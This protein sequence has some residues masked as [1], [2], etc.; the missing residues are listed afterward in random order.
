MFA[1]VNQRRIKQLNLVDLSGRFDTVGHNI[2]LKVMNYD[3]SI[4][5]G[6]SPH[7]HDPYLSV[8]IAKADPNQIEFDEEVP[9]GS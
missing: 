2:I 8:F 7:A 9:R 4:S 5:W 6:D 3:V 1:N